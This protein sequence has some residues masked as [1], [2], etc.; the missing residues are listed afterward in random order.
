MS[1]G[2]ASWNIRNSLK[3][4]H[5]AMSG[6]IWY[7]KNLGTDPKTSAPQRIYGPGI[8]AHAAGCSAGICEMGEKRGMQVCGP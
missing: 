8:A 3:G 1:S 2:E 5:I 7:E 6:K 4:R